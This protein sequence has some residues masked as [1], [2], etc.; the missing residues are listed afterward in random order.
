ML[1]YHT[2]KEDDVKMSRKNVNITID[3]NLYMQIKILSNKLNVNIN[4]LLEEGIR[5]ILDKD[6]EK[7]T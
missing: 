3:E 5:Y 7:N 2:N 4:D 6:S 1:Y